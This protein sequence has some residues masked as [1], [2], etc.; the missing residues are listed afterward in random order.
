MSQVSLSEVLAGVLIASTLA[1]AGACAATTP[2]EQ[3]PA[4][5]HQRCEGLMNW[6]VPFV[7]PMHSRVIH[8]AL[9]DDWGVAIDASVDAEMGSIGGLGWVPKLASGSRSDS[10]APLSPAAPRIAGERDRARG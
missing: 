6:M 2:V 1:G 4:A 3:M 9:T 8:P 10:I 7:N 5:L